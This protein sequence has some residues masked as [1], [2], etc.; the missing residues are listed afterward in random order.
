MPDLHL[1]GPFADWIRALA[2]GK[3]ELPNCEGDRHHYVPEF[4]L[5]R[6]R[7]PGRT[8]SQLD[9]ET[10]DCTEVRPKDAAWETNLYTVESTSGQH[11]GVIEGFFSV[12]ENFAAESLN[13]LLKTPAKFT[14]EDRGNLAFLLTIQEQR[15]PG[16]LEEWEENLALMGTVW[17]TVELANVAGSK[18]AKR[19]ARDAAKAITDGRVNLKPTKENALTTALMGFGTTVG[20]A[21]LLPWTVL[22]ARDGVF[23]CSDR[24]LTMR[25]PAPPHKFSAGAWMSSPFAYATMP[26]SSTACLRVSP[27]DGQRFTERQTVTQ[28]DHIN[29]RTYGW[30]TRYV[31]GSSTVALEALHARARA[32]P[33]AVPVPRRKRMVLLEDLET[34]DPAVAERNAAKGW[35]R[36]VVK[37]EDDGSFRLMSYEVIESI[38]DA[39]RAVAPREERPHGREWPVELEGGHP[40]A[41]SATGGP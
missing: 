40:T 32:D 20:P 12:A 2:E 33:Q 28:V 30:A 22:R 37:H 5:K 27:R 26:L 25:D 41:L 13:R 6:F 8:L 36:H 21:Y 16:Y 10:G 1:P 38:K 9:K 15:A 35:D 23:V 34:A 18:A 29:L 39:R 11:D 31:Y 24:P 3:K 19:R 4:V 17:A 14:D 7:G